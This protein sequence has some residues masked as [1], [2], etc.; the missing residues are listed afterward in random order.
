VAG[1]WLT[2]AVHSALGPL[3]HMRQTR[4]AHPEQL[5]AGLARLAGALCTFSL[6]ADPRQLPLYQHDEPEACFD[7]LERH[8]MRQLE[9]MLPSNCLSVPILP[10]EPGFY[11]G[12]IADPRALTRGRWFLGVRS[13]AGQGALMGDVPRLVKLCSAEHIVKLVQR[14]YPGL[15]LESAPVPPREISP[16]IGMQYFSVQTNPPAASAGEPCWKFI[17][18]TATVGIYVPAAI[19]EVG[20]ELSI[21]LEP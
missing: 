10:A 3:R 14:A 12:A 1:F 8:I 13:S 9:V 2:H 18:E 19:P 7:G 11:R 6:E 16:R 20:L 4:S 15:V 21:V 5:F 17:A